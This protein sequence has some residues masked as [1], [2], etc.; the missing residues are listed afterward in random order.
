MACRMPGAGTPSELWSV[1][2]D[3]G[4]ATSAVPPE[5]NLG[6]GRAGLIDG[7]DEFDAGFFGIS[8]REAASMD[9]QQGL[10]L[11]LCW[12]G[13]EDAGIVGHR[14]EPLAAGVFVGVMANDF[15]D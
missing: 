15:T 13:L 3:G 7:G 1:L 6:I 10:M 11:E 14:P 8:P 2:R 12:E 9:P 4:D 5:R